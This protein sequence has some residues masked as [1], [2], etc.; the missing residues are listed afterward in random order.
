MDI[1][2]SQQENSLGRGYGRNCILGV[3]FVFCFL[4]LA[5]GVVQKNSVV[6][7]DKQI[8][9]YVALHR[10][11]DTA[12][13][14]LFFT[15]LGSSTVITGLGVG[16]VAFFSFLRKRR[17]IYFLITSI[18]AG[19][20]FY[21]IFKMLVQR[22]RPDTIYAWVESGGYSFPSGH[23]TSS[24]LFYGLIGFF[25]WRLAQKQ[26]MKTLV[27]VVFGIIIFLIGFSRFYLGVHW[28]SDVLAG[29]ILGGALL[30]AFAS[31]FDAR[32]KFKLEPKKP[33]LLTHQQILALVLLSCLAVGT[34]LYQYYVQHPLLIQARQ[35]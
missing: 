18:I 13:I 15:H 4:G 24:T 14:F 16:L 33:I 5:Y 26:W 27:I 17:Q 3:F 20:L 32:E 9:S 35:Q 28:P 25:M 8:M 31:F 34:F 1:E 11:Y 7:V 10:T 29:W 23:T 2:S 12:R 22:M 30:V 19:Q 21:W 6:E